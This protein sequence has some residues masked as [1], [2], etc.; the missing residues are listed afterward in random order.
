MKKGLQIS[1]LII[2]MAAFY[3]AFRAGQALAFRL[4]EWNF[5][6]T[7]EWLRTW[8]LGGS[9]LVLAGCVVVIWKDW[10]R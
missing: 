9:V 7:M 8:I 2:G 10:D 3:F 5:E 1:K 4:A 6:G